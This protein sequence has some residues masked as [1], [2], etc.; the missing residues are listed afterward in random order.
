LEI[1]AGCG[2]ERKNGKW[3]QYVA[4]VEEMENVQEGFREKIIFVG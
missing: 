1:R 3:M 4:N 2:I